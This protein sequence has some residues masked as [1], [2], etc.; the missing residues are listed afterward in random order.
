MSHI[1]TASAQSREDFES[2]PPVEDL[3]AEEIIGDDD[4]NNVKMLNDIFVPLAIVD[5]IVSYIPSSLEQQVKLSLVSRTFQRAAFRDVYWRSIWTEAYPGSTS[6]IRKHFRYAYVEMKALC[7]QNP[8]ALKSTKKK[9]LC[10]VRAVLLGI[11]GSGKSSLANR[12]AQTST[13]NLDQT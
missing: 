3:D 6:I 10:E 7:K 8:H 5:Q 12:F 2:L 9:I 11:D 4:G 1:V 13:Y